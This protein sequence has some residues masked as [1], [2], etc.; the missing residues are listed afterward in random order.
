MVFLS[1]D[2]SIQRS[3]E[4]VQER[5]KERGVLA[6]ITGERQFRLVLHYWIDDAGVEETVAAFREAVE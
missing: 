6:G 1:L 2:E 4:D 3:T 5:L